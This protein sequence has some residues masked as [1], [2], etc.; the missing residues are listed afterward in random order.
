MVSICVLTALSSPRRL[1]PRVFSAALMII[2]RYLG[3]TPN[4]SRLACCAPY[5]RARFF[6]HL[7][8]RICAR[9]THPTTHNTRTSLFCRIVRGAS[10]RR[11]LFS[12]TARPRT[13]RRRFTLRSLHTVVPCQCPMQQRNRVLRLTIVALARPSH[14]ICSV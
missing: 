11:I 7:A 3:T 13:S 1:C 9:I 4:T 5:A 12:E 2:P 8:G 14:S 10:P 6:L